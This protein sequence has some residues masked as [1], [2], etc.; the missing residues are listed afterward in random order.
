MTKSL[1]FDEPREGEFTQGTVFSCSYAESYQDTS[2]FGLVITA[3]CDAAQDK[4]QIYNYI[5]L[6]S[7]NDWVLADGANIAMD[8]I[9]ADCLNTLKNYL[10]N[11]SLSESLLHTKGVDEIYEAH[12]RHKEN[13]GRSATRCQKVKA[14]M[15]AYKENMK[16]RASCDSIEA[17][18]DHLKSN[19]NKVES[20]VKEL[21][22]NRLAGF[23]LLQQMPTLSGDSGNYVALLREIHH[24]PT[25]LVREIVAGLSKDVWAL[26]NDKRMRCP[27]FYGDDDLAAPVAKLKS[28]WIE[29][30]M[31]Q[32]SM[33]F[34]RIGVTDNDFTSVKRSLSSIGLG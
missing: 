3:R 5:P 12:F 34:S 7:L 31:Q 6:V 24:I 13:D 25:S 19:A 17:R 14:A 2:V 10:K 28:P 8:R 26:R 18:R 22:D 4:T 33:L 11:E 1:M 27:R 23:Y 9:H 16:H 15:D 30:L 21:T 20:V 32:F 29:H